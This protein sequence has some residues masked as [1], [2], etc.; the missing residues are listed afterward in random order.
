MSYGT[1][2]ILDSLLIDMSRFRENEFLNNKNFT[3]EQRIIPLPLDKVFFVLFFI[4][5]P[6][7]SGYSQMRL[8]EAEK[9]FRERNSEKGFLT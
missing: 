9:I 8:S 4:V 2:H 1:A 7:Y 3:Q 6:H 5:P